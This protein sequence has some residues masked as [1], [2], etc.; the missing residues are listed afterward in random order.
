MAT[1]SIAVLEAEIDG[2]KSK[3]RQ[4]AKNNE[5]LETLK[6]QLG[7]KL[8][9]MEKA[10]P[11]E[12]RY[13]VSDATIEK[14]QEIL[15]VN[16]QGV[17]VAFD[18]L[19]GW[20]QVMERAGREGDREFS[21]AA[22]EG[23]GDYYVD[24][25]SRGSLYIP[26][27]CLSVIGGIQP[28]KLKRYVEEAMSKGSGG[29]GML[30]RFQM[31]VWI[32]NLGDWDPPQ[33]WPDNEAKERAYQVFKSLDEMKPLDLGAISDSEGG[34]PYLRFNPD[35]QALYDHWRSELENRLRGDGLKATPAFESHLGKY[36]SLMPS[37]ALLFHLLGSGTSGTGISGSC[38]GKFSA[39]SLEAAQ[40]AADWCD[41]LEAHA[42]VVYSAEVSPG[43]EAAHRL[44]EKIR[45]GQIHH[46]EPVRDIYRHH[47]G[48]LATAT[49]VNAGLEVLAE[50][51]WVRTVT[52]P[53]SG[54]PITVIHLHPDL[55]GGES[56]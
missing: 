21:L 34:I 54:A 5:S 6:G 39:V 12:Q 29:D 53:T 42:R 9:E 28:D 45:A 41:Y 31:M 19:A 30:Q 24:R 32:D 2:I 48:G 8:A 26:A 50:A 17:L 44:A 7:E 4:A 33:S 15:M 36:R 23:T 3:M 14:L 1:A 43:L 40:L 37:L 11:S 52:Q 25:I 13:W 18:E 55:R 22:W 49:E 46:G 47:W 38:G 27:V 56:A 10:R 20:F 16:P 35:A 51:G